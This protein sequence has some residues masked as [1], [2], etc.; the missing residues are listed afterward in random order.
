MP[1]TDLHDALPM[2]EKERKV[3]PL[4]DLKGDLK[5]ALVALPAG[6]EI[7]THQA[8]HAASVQLIEGSVEILKGTEWLRPTRGERIAFEI[9]QPHGM[10]AL[11]SSYLLVTHW[12]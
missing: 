11:A 10:K 1:I 4:V 8:P 9:G 2:P 5:V 6:V 3:L 7:A 12:R